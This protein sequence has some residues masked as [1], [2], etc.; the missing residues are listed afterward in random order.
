MSAWTKEQVDV[1]VAGSYRE[2]ALAIDESSADLVWSPPAVCARARRSIRTALTVVRRGATSCAAVLLVPRRDGPARDTKR[3]LLG[4]HAAWVDP[5]STSGYLSAMAHLREL[6]LDPRRHLGA[7][8]FAGTYRDAILEVAAGRA[9]V[10]SFY[11]V[12]D[13]DA[14]TLREA[15]DVA[16][17][18]AARLSILA[19]TR[20]APFDALVIPSRGA[21]S[22][23]L[24]RRILSLDSTGKTPAM[25]LEAC[26][27][28]SFRRTPPSAYAVL[29]RVQGD[30]VLDP[31][32]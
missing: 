30:L 16:G 32:A 25:L 9:D 1:E 23:E 24:E 18:D 14:A 3:A 15:V 31:V 22:P 27:A 28:D 19:V 2:L 29:D 4:A 11:R 13:D 8:R 20:T 12:E 6:G 21:V 26:R 10:T 7:Q 17:P 5:L